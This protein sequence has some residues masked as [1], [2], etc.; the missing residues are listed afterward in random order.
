MQEAYGLMGVVSLHA[1]RGDKGI[2]R[3]EFDRIVGAHA[4]AI[5]E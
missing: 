4:F 3:F 5:R 1:D 2:R